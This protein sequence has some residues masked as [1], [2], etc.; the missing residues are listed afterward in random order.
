M[1]ISAVEPKILPDNLNLRKLGIMNDEV[2]KTEEEKKLEQTDKK[3]K[4]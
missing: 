3:D 1:I 4:P 2:W